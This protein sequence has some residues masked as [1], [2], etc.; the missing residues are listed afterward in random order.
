MNKGEMLL[1]KKF[2]VVHIRRLVNRAI[3]LTDL[4][5]NLLLADA[6]RHIDD[7]PQEVEKYGAA[8]SLAPAKAPWRYDYA[9]ALYKT[10]QFD[11]AVR[12]LKVWNVLNQ[13]R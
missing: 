10:K 8:L 1:P 7:Y 12:Q 6:A 3:G 2:L 13:F 5:K 4:E 11:E 9:F